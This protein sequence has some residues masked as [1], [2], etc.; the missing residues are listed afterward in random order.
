[1]Q[2][3]ALVLAPW[4]APHKLYDWHQSISAVLGKKANVLEEYEETVSA[5]S[6][7]LRIPAVIQLRKHLSR[8]KN[9]VKFSRHNVYLRDGFR[10]QYCGER[11]ESR[12][13]TYDHVTPRSKGGL[14]N[15]TN[16]VAACRHDNGRKGNR[17]PE[18]AGMRLLT[19]PVKPKSLPLTGAL[20]LPRAVPEL[21]LP[22]LEG[23]RTLQRAG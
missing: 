9:D 12:E 20:A 4:M 11:F 8:T 23:Y 10:C 17:T 22:Y 7:T 14:T 2:H 16:I 19:R 13:L 3:V 5:P 6:I 21:W 1:V 15:W 18:Q